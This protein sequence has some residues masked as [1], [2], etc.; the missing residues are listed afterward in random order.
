ME[1]CMETA[2]GC[3]MPPSTYVSVRLSDTLKQGKYDPNRSY[4]F[5]NF[6]DRRRQAKIDIFRLVGS[7]G[8]MVSADEVQRI[9]EVMVSSNDP[10][11]NDLR[12]KVTAKQANANKAGTKPIAPLKKDKVRRQAEQYLEKHRVQEKVSSAMQ[13]LLQKQ[14]EDPIDFLCSYLQSLKEP[15]PVPQSMP[16]ATP[17]PKVTPA[18]VR[19]PALAAANT[20][21]RRLRSELAPDNAGAYYSQHVLPAV[22]P[23]A[24]STKMY[25]RFPDPRKGVQSIA[26]TNTYATAGTDA[27]GDACA[28]AAANVY[29]RMLE[30]RLA[31]VEAQFAA[32]VDFHVQQRFAN[33]AC[34]S[35]LPQEDRPF[36]SAMSEDALNILLQA[37]A[38]L[39]GRNARD[40]S[41]EVIL[42]AKNEA[43]ATFLKSLGLDTKDK[44]VMSR[45]L[46]L[47][48]LL[49]DSC[50][51]GVLAQ[52][53]A[54]IKAGEKWSLK[55]SAGTWLANP[56]PQKKSEP[57][58]TWNRQP[59][60]PV[61]ARVKPSES[62]WSVSPSL[63]ED[64][65]KPSWNKRPSIGTWLHVR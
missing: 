13:H 42:L 36:V 57:G 7:S 35:T 46:E 15:K 31:A 44:E 17:A 11:I 21:Y 50:D 3:K 24:L 60:E 30:I 49:E 20:Y 16:E 43:K 58:N 18:Y 51:S 19:A 4:K 26:D 22:L 62:L 40:F 27:G 6:K 5:D 47:K 38:M 61:I 33:L 8:V 32:K 41:S 48:Q 14:P 10:I 12:L 52:A 65:P 55:P 39:M 25:S 23:P 28:M 63:E 45:L 56:A 54:E 64:P 53:L 37:E 29:N 34:L 2:D 9:S 1:I 59:G